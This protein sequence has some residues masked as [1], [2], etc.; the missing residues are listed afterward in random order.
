MRD[1]PRRGHRRRPGLRGRRPGSRRARRPRERRPRLKGRRAMR[2]ARRSPRWPPRQPR[3][4]R[5]AGSPA[6]R[7]HR[8]GSDAGRGMPA[9]RAEG[10]ACGRDGACP[11]PIAVAG[12]PPH[13]REVPPATRRLRR[14]RT[15]GLT[16]AARSLSPYSTSSV[17]EKA[18]QGCSARSVRP[19]SMPFPARP[20]GKPSMERPVGRTRLT[21]RNAALRSACS[22]EPSS[23]SSDSPCTADAPSSNLFTIS[24]RNLG[25]GVESASITTT[26][27]GGWGRARS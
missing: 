6:R 12:R 2:E 19:K 26:A 3:D 9:R 5:A 10:S 23:R 8:E 18:V 20:A 21:R 16:P 14:G 4:S 27:L 7:R 1:R 15:T 22:A 25:S 24:V 13:V 11:P 17:L